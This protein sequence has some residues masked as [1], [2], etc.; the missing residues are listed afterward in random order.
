MCDVAW[1][2]RAPALGLGELHVGA[3]HGEEVWSQPADGQL[4]HTGQEPGHCGS[5][6]ED[7]EIE[8]EVG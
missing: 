5:K 3:A 1:V 8:V 6:Q 7:F 4:A 2:L